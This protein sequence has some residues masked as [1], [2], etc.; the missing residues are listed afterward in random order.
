M[1]LGPKVDETASIVKRAAS[2]R[3]TDT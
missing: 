2:D 1:A 3:V